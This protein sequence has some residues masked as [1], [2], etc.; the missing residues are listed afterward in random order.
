MELI[1]GR[2]ERRS[3]LTEMKLL[4]RHILAY[5]LKRTRLD[6]AAYG[7]LRVIKQIA[8]NA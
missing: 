1:F 7:I 8:T 5:G 6:Q 4:K 3:Y 2:Y